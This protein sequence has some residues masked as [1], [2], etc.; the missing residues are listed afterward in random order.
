[1]NSITSCPECDF[2]FIHDGVYVNYCVV[3]PKDDYWCPTAF[4]LE[5]NSLV[6]KYIKCPN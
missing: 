2:P 1:M 4:D 3:E 5:R 6:R